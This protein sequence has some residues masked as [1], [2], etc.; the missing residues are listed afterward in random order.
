MPHCVIM[1][2]MS[3]DHTFIFMYMR[4]YSEYELDRNL[5]KY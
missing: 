5:N 2:Q 1:Q 4:N 3:Q